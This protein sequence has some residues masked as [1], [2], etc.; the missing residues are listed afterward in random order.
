MSDRYNFIHIPKTGGTS[1]KYALEETPRPNITFPEQGHGLTLKSLNNNA[2]FIIRQPWL[3]FCSAYWERATM[4]ERRELSKTNSYKS[5]GYANLSDHEKSILEEYKTPNDL[6]SYLRAGNT[7]P[8]ILGELT[9]PHNKWLGNLDEYKRHEHKVKLAFALK[10]LNKALKVHFGLVV[11][12]DP[13]RRR[14]RKLFKKEQ[15]YDITPENL[16]WFEYHRKNEYELLDYI[17][18][19]PYFYE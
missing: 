14:S 6:I 3:K 7:L 16:E 19:R 5:F 2:C 11:P 12:Q 15:S 4:E 13:F 17:R 8:G 10:D 18:T 1:I 9:S